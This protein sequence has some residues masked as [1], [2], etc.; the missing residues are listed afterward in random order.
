MFWGAGAHAGRPP[1]SATIECAAVTGLRPFWHAPTVSLPNAE[2]ERRQTR[3]PLRP[4]G[5]RCR[6]SPI[7]T[8]AGNAVLIVSEVAF[9][10][11]V[12]SRYDV[13]V[14]IFVMARY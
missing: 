5:R 6:D 11:L 4:L 7:I 9:V 13:A 8:L 14:I 1:T 2:P 10:I 3:W 12:V